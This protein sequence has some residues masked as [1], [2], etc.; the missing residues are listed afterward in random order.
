MGVTFLLQKQ[1]GGDHMWNEFWETV[2]R[3]LAGK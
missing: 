1:K 3:L 2:R